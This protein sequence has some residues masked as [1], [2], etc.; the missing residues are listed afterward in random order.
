[1]TVVTKATPD[2][3]GSKCFSEYQQR[4]AI[5]HFRSS[6]LKYTQL[7]FGRNRPRTAPNQ[8]LRSR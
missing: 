8:N 2:R 6:E 4:Q 3:S 7:A 1:M 5:L